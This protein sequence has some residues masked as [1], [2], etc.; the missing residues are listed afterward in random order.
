MIASDEQQ[1][2]RR[3]LDRT[4]C[5]R[6]CESARVARAARWNAASRAEPDDKYRADGVAGVSLRSP[7]PLSFANLE[8][9]TADSRLGK[10]LILHAIVGAP[11]TA[12]RKATLPRRFD[13]SAKRA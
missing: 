10:R 3:R 1:H 9:A 2:W 5:A 13:S 6:R 4:A 12:T 7:A 8:N 11:L